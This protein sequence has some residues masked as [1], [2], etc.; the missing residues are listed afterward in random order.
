VDGAAENFG[1]LEGAATEVET[2]FVVVD[3]SDGT[4]VSG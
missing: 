1:L 2:P 3:D 4:V